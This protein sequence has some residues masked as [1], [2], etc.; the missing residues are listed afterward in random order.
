MSLRRSPRFV[1]L[2]VLVTTLGPMSMQM[3]LPSI[4]AVR[5]YFAVEAGVAWLALSLPMVAI[6]VATMIFGP[7]SDR[8]GR[9]PVLLTGLAVFI[10]GSVLGAT[11]DDIGLVILARVLQA[12]GASAGITLARAMTR[13]VYGFA[14]ALRV[15]S[16]LTIAMVVAP[17]IAPVFGG[18]LQDGFGWRAI[19]VTMLAVGAATLP[20][21]A[22]GLVETLPQRV[23]GG[24]RG[25]ALGTRELMGSRRYL[26]YALVSATSMSIFFGFIAAAP[27]LMTG[28]MGR[29]ASE[30]GVWFMSVSAVF[31]LGT[32]LSTRL[33]NRYGAD[34]LIAAGTALAAVLVLA[35]IPL[36]LALPLTPALLFVPAILISVVQGL[37][38][39]NCMA[40]AVNVQPRLAGSASGLIG[41]L[42][43]MLAA[44]V[45]QSIGELADGTSRPMLWFMAGNALASVALLALIRPFGAAAAAAVPEASR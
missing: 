9:K 14:S 35:M 24:W 19:F 25:L 29:S 16:Y 40:S 37:V 4:D 17:T 34:R 11:A 6:A 26:G 36:H 31:A 42:Q 15:T 2:L 13:D 3:F 10:A 43:M 38:I 18:L 20:F 7:L 45:S 32:F 30:Y 12:S 22:F 28:V 23:A 44:A 33:L 1:V 27:Y 8:F 5:A 41:F 21:V 39:S